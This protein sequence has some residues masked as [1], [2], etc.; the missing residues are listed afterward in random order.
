MAHVFRGWFIAPATANHRFHMSCDDMCD[1]WLGDTPDQT[2]AV[3][4]ILNDINY[5]EYRRASYSTA[6]DD[7]RV[8]AWVSMT[9]G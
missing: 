7:V 6:Y 4:E 2:T 1:L 8:S 9:A 5:S 3:T